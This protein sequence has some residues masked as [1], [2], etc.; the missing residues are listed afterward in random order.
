MS[1]TALRSFGAG[2]VAPALHARADLGLYRTALR[3]LQNGIVMKTG[4]IQSR[5]GTVYKGASKSNGWARLIPI[6][7]DDDQNY[8]LELG[9][10]YVRFWKDGAQIT[11]T[12]IGSW[13][14]ATAY[15]AGIVLLHSGTYYTCLQA[16]TSATANDRPNDGTNRLL[17]WHALTGL[18]Y[19]LPTPWTTQTEVRQVQHQVEAAAVRFVHRTYSRRKLVRV[20][21][22]QWYFETLAAASQGLAAPTNLASDAPG[23]GTVARWV[24]TAYNSGTSTESLPSSAETSNTAPTFGA[25]ITLTWDAVTGADS[26]RVYRSD[27]GGVYGFLSFAGAGT[28]YIDDDSYAPNTA[29]TPPESESVPDIDTAGDYPGVIGAYQ[30]RLLLSGSTSSPDT[31]QTSR[32]GSPDDFT[33]STPLVDADAVSWRMVGPRLIRPRHFL[34]VARR[35]VQFANIGEYVIEGDDSGI[36]TPGAVNPRQVS[37]NGAAAYPAP[38]LV[39]QSALYVQERG[40]IVRDL[41]A[42]NAG[43]DLTV[44]AMHLVAGY[45]IVDWAYQQTP[46]S[47]VW[48]VRSDGVLLSLTYQRESGVFAWARHVTDGT[49]EACAVVPEST[50]DALYLVVNRTI[51]GGTVRYL[52]RL[53]LRSAA[54]AAFVGCDAAATLLGAHPHDGLSIAASAGTYINDG[55][56][57]VDVVATGSGGSGSF[58]A[59]DVGRTFAFD[60]SGRRVIGRVMTYTSGTVVRV[61]LFASGP[62]PAFGELANPT[63][64]TTGNWWWTSVRGLDHLEGESVSVVLDGVVLASPYNPD[65][66]LTVTVADGIANFWGADPG[67]G[68]D[69]TLVA[70][71]LETAA[72]SSAFTTAIVGLPFVVNVETLGLDGVS[73]SAK[74]GTFQLTKVGLHLE[75]S[76]GCFVGPQEPTTA[77]GLTLPGG[78]ALQYLTPRDEDE[79][80][81]TAPLSGYR[82][83]HIESHCSRTGRVY[84]RHV[85][86][87]PLTITAIVPIGTFPRT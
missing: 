66:A 2:E 57:Y 52:E 33:S 68:V 5:A 69:I 14:N 43:S 63:V 81:V 45:T 15:A 39:D 67:G 36:I 11:G 85:D 22:A 80:A 59:A 9:D 47:V 31:V 27:S 72:Y 18:I 51:D 24:V 42:D 4:G 61:D 35:L 78:G 65:S 37:G 54:I 76:L 84:I 1:N 13:A 71:Y 64:L 49:V 74:E 34:E 19:E 28:S 7:F 3:A 12:S 48:A 38:L 8:L 40:G 82:S 17:Y 79:N 87:T 30:Q 50:E 55:Y 73:R 41:L 70:P 53:A 16:H 6:V 86:P 10:E 46:N 23:A 58:V 44:T 77:T 62:S 26:Y 75:D 83:L 56:W 21:D 60:V 20:A 25:P 32:V 29:I